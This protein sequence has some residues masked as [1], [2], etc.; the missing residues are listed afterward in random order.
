MWPS[1]LEFTRSLRSVSCS[2]SCI[3]HCL[4]TSL[5]CIH[6][7]H[8]RGDDGSWSHPEVAEKTAPGWS[9][10]LDGMLTLVISYP[11]K[12]RCITPTI[13]TLFYACAL[14]LKGV[15]W[16]PLAYIYPYPMS[17]TSMIGSYSVLCYRIPVEVE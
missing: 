17:L 1:T 8:N 15:E 2:P 16:N 9:Y 13:L 12:P 3:Y 7:C 14:S 5:H 6:E 4:F 11:G 10:R